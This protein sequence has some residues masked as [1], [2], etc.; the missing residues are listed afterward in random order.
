MSPADTTHREPVAIV[1]PAPCWWIDRDDCW[2]ITHHPTREDAQADHADRVRSIFGW[3]LSV[4]GAFALYPGVTRQ[5]PRRCYK[6]TCPECGVPQ[7]TQDRWEACAAECGYEIETAQ[8]PPA[9]PDQ[10]R[11]FEALPT[12]DIE[13]LSLGQVIVFA[14]EDPR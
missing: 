2:E 1:L 4:A 13:G 5:E 14:E 11:L 3:V 6:V 10:A 8:I 9:D 12:H 7:H